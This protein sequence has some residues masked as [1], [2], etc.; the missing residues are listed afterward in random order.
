MKIESVTG[1]R[2]LIQADEWNRIN[3]KITSL[4]VEHTGIVE[5]KKGDKTTINMP[6]GSMCFIVKHVE[7]FEDDIHL[8][9]MTRLHL[10]RDGSDPNDTYTGDLG[11]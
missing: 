4:E 8:G 2:T 3:P 10:E 1:I 11:V 9:D 7:Y 5:I 6:N